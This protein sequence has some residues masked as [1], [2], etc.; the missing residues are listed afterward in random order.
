MCQWIVVAVRVL[1]INCL[2][3]SL[4]LTSHPRQCLGVISP[5]HCPASPAL[6]QITGCEQSVQLASCLNIN[7]PTK[8]KTGAMPS[9]LP[10][11]S[12]H[13]CPLGVVYWWWDWDWESQLY[14][15]SP[16]LPLFLRKSPLMVQP[17]SHCECDSSESVI[18]LTKEEKMQS[19][20][21]RF[22]Q[23]VRIF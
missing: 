3:S 15:A 14:W 18:G 23:V 12:P 17:A 7:F 8:L 2:R 20:I 22:N 21:I 4:Q 10:L 9:Q 1:Y 13:L 11:F 19:S 16:L 6:N 5:H